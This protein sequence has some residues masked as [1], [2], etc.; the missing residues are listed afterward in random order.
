MN[1][2]G[3]SFLL[4]AT[5]FVACSSNNDSNESNSKI[6]GAAKAIKDAKA[7]HAKN[8]SKKESTFVPDRVFFDTDE[9]S[10]S[11]DSEVTAQIQ[12]QDIKSN[13]IKSITISGYCDERGGI[14]YNQALGERRANALKSSLQKL[15]VDAKVKVISYGKEKALVEGHNET[16]WA[17]NRIAVVEY[18]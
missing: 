14:E 11:G 7:N 13:N 10:I 18:K 3:L 5:F 2:K 16:A 4:V 1:I 6:S 17:Q 12:A 15:G 8:L 9:S